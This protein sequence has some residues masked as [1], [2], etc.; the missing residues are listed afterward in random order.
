MDDVSG[1]AGKSNDFSKFLTVSRKFHYIC[2]YI[3]HIIYRTKSI[4]QMT[5]S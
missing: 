5:L 4:W 2:L 3:F 1:L